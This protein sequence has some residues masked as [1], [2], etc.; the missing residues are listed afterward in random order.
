LKIQKLKLTN[1]NDNNVN[2]INKNSFYNTLN[3]FIMLITECN[4]VLTINGWKR[5]TNLLKETDYIACLN[6]DGHL[7]FK[8]LK[9]VVSSNT[10]NS[11]AFVKNENVEIFASSDSEL[12]IKYY[13]DDRFNPVKIKDID[14]SRSFYIK[15]TCNG[16]IGKNTIQKYGTCGE[17]TYKTNINIYNDIKFNNT[18]LKMIEAGYSI[19]FTKIVLNNKLEGYNLYYSIFDSFLTDLNEDFYKIEN[20]IKIPLLGIKCHY[21]E[22]INYIC[23]QRSGKMVWIKY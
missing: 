16:V 22:D 21:D 18:I 14:K 15:K 8:L 12:N 7:V 2:N 9:N 19:D 6:N 13:K 11:T 10:K 3:N 1:E 17:F 20:D 5:S 23:I 4:D